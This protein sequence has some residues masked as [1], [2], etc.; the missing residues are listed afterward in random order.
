MIDSLT[1]VSG[2][3]YRRVCEENM[4]LK[5]ILKQE[6]H[7]GRPKTALMTVTAAKEEDCDAQEWSDSMLALMKH[8][9]TSKQLLD[10]ALESNQDEV[11]LELPPPRTINEAKPFIPTGKPKEP[12]PEAIK[13]KGYYVAREEERELAYGGKPP[14]GYSSWGDYFKAL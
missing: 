3:E 4:K 5:A 12:S 2:M 7:K 14:H 9:K 13:A 11:H 10:E 8:C 1:T 6:I